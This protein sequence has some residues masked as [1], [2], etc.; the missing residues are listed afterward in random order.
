MH[1]GARRFA[2]VPGG[3]GHQG[4]TTLTLAAIRQPELKDALTTAWRH[5]LPKRSRRPET[6]RISLMSFSLEW[7]RD[8][9]VCRF[10]RRSDA[11]L[12]R[13]RCGENRSLA[14]RND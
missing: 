12:R 14:A 2:L 6:T 11:G 13:R 7:R 5:A 8:N 1:D 4:W 9:R 10:R 3:W